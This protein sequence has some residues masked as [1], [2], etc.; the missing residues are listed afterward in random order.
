MY[1]AE[2]LPCNHCLAISLYFFCRPIADMIG[3]GPARCERQGDLSMH[4]QDSARQDL[5]IM[6]GPLAQ[7]GN[8]VILCAG[9]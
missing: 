1:I 5:A 8:R 7:K 3:N 4:C 6:L 2:D 9:C